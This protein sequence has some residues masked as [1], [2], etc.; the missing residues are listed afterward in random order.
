MDLKFNFP[1]TRQYRVPGMGDSDFLLDSCILGTSNGAWRIG[2]T[3][4]FITLC[5]QQ[6]HVPC[7]GLE[8]LARGLTR[9]FLQ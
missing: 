7:I 2:R 1:T 3:V 8:A 5:I 4:N 6:T 9:R